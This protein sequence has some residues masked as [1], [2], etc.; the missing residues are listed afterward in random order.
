M[1]IFKCFHRTH[2]RLYSLPCDNIAISVGAHNGYGHPQSDMLRYLGR[3]GIVEQTKDVG[4]IEKD[5]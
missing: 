4:D 1:I 5:L 2:V 3:L